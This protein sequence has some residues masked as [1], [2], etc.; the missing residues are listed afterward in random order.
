MPAYGFRYDY[1]IEDSP[2]KYRSFLTVS[3]HPL[4]SDVSTYE[5]EFWVSEVFET[6]ISPRKYFKDPENIKKFFTARSTGVGTF[7]GLTGV[8]LIA[9]LLAL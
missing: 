2:L 8:A 4:F 5:S 7:V 3:T 6:T 1:F 9:V